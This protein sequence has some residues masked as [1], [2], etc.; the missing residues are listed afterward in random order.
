MPKEVLYDI[1]WDVMQHFEKTGGD[2][3]TEGVFNDIKDFAV[4]QHEKR[5]KEA[6]EPAQDEYDET[7]VAEERFD[8][9]GHL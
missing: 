8:E 6:Q 7:E 2:H 5:L 3:M 9:K 4:I 1:V